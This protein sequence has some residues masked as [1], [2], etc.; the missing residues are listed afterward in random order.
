MDGISFVAS[1]VALAEA[2]FKV[3]EYL[4]DVQGSDKQR[5]RLSVEIGALYVVID[6]VKCQLEDVSSATTLKYLK[7]LDKPNG[8]LTQC[9]KVVEELQ[10]KLSPRHGIRAG[11]K[12]VAWP[13]EK[14]E[15]V[16]LVTRV[17][18]LQTIINTALVQAN[19]AI[20]E[21]ILTNSH[22]VK[23][24]LDDKETMELLNWLS[25][26]NHAAQ[27]EEHCRVRCDGT[28]KWFLDSEAF[29]AWNNGKFPILWC[30]GIPGSGKTITASLAYSHLRRIYCPSDV[31]VLGVYCDFKSSQAGAQTAEKLIGSLL[32]QVIQ[33]S[34]EV[35]ESLKEM[36]DRHKSMGTCPRLNDYAKEL[37]S[38]LATFKRAFLVIDA[39]DEL[40]SVDDR[41]TFMRVI[42]AF[43]MNVSIM[44]TA[45]AT[46]DVE[47]LIGPLHHICDVCESR[48]EAVLFHCAEHDE[49]GYDVCQDC[50]DKGTDH[51]PENAHSDLTRLQNA[52]EMGITAD[53]D[54]VKHYAAIRIT[55]DENLQELIAENWALKQLIIEVVQKSCQSM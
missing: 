24:M 12:A 47:K 42:R 2:T 17:H 4:H 37:D 46:V 20:S 22:A 9:Q 16:K 31:A 53:A 19:L 18:R 32:K 55:R 23:R 8:P 21:H 36:H 30:P 39:L 11:L 25:P 41:A 7:S 45:R 29:Q 3:V 51:C 14:E 43:S 27:Q 40:E 34:A 50:F 10:K 38:R 1:V 35:P 26:L 28:G 6:N 44:V 13:F 33:L 52:P 54:D 49:G 5:I 15:V 48:T